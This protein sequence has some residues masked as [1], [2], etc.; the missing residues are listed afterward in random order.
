MCCHRALYPAR[1]LGPL[2]GPKPFSTIRLIFA[3]LIDPSAFADT[4]SLRLEIKRALT[5]LEATYDADEAERCLETLRL[6][7]TVLPESVAG[8]L[9]VALMHPRGHDRSELPLSSLGNTE[10]ALDYYGLNK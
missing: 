2:S 4:E 5:M 3:D 7:P 6:A 1:H 9:E 8:Q 10:V